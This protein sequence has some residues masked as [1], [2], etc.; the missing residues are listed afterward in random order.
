MS[1]MQALLGPC[2]ALALIVL[3]VKQKNCNCVLVLDWMGVHQTPLSPWKV[4]PLAS[5]NQAL[6]PDMRRVICLDPHF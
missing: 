1:L 2:G 6:A 5:G 4:V 3:E